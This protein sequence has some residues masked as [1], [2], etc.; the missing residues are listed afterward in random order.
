VR[1]PGRSLSI[2]LPLGV[3]ILLVVGVLSPFAVAG[4]ADSTEGENAL[5]PTVAEE[6]PAIPDERAATVDGDNYDT[7]QAAVDAAAPG[8]SVVLTG[9]F[10]ERV[11]VNTSGITLTTRDGA[12]IDADG[13]GRVLTVRAPNVIVEHLWLRNS[14]SDLGNEDAGVFLAERAN[15]AV[16]RDIHMT[17]ITFGVWVNGADRVRIA[18]CYI[19]GRPDVE[20]RTDRGNGIN[21][22]ETTDTVV[23]DNAITAVRDGIYYSWAGNVTSTDNVM[24]NNRYGVHYMYSDDNRLLNNTAVDNDVG[25]ALMVS[26]R[27]VVANNTA[28]RNDGI[29]GHGVLLKDIERSTVRDNTYVGNDHG[30]YAFNAQDN[31]IT[32]NLLRRNGVGMHV[33]ADSR[34]QT[35]TGNSFVENGNA[36]RTTTNRVQSWNDSERGNYWHGARTADIDGDRISEIRH[37]PAGLIERLVMERPQVAVFAASPAF[38]VVRMAEASFPV[39]ETPG[40]VDH[41]PLAESPHDWRAT[42]DVDRAP[43]IWAEDVDGDPMP[44]HGGTQH[45]ITAPT[46][47][48]L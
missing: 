6:P 11:V 37:R 40:V 1:L 24:W 42:A 43:V 10:D 28:L 17:E 26:Q 32:G 20:R 21:L 15:D 45:A 19:K 18:E 13:T 23:H 35:V 7:V 22:W 34:G 2:A 31:R 27:L 14:G 16:L 36:V 44:T 9:R 38:E 8:E 41:H 3:L 25:Y 12:V 46:G 48:T 29:S 33:T 30:I 39:L 5:E 47:G 4:A